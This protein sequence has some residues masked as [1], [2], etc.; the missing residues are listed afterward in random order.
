MPS[1]VGQCARP[2]LTGSPSG[3]S[4]LSAQPVKPS[5]RSI[6]KLDWTLTFIT[7]QGMQ[8]LRAVSF[9]PKTNTTLYPSS[10]RFAATSHADPK[11]FTLLVIAACVFSCYVL[12]VHNSIPCL[13]LGH[14]APRLLAFSYHAKVEHFWEIIAQIACLCALQK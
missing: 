3:L 4:F 1:L 6:C 9:L 7:E 8:R 5:T 11:P 13:F 14:L 12:R 10:F 2:V